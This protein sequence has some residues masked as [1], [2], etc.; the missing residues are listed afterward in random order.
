MR[1]LW[2]FPQG[3][4]EFAVPHQLWTPASNTSTA[5]SP[6]RRCP[7]SIA[8]SNQLT[9]GSRHPGGRSRTAECWRQGKRCNSFWYKYNEWGKHSPCL[10]GWK[11]GICQVYCPTGASYKIHLS[12]HKKVQCAFCPQKFFNTRSLDQ[13]VRERHQDQPGRQAQVSCRCSPNCQEKFPSMKEMEIHMRHHNRK[14]L[15]LT[16]SYKGCFD[17]FFLIAGLL[18]HGASHGLKSWDKTPAPPGEG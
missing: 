4:W 7:A 11:C 8:R 6:T 1:S 15:P 9:T 5:T 2:Q 10:P 18:Q 3:G 12:T 13:H 16:C 14:E 17:C